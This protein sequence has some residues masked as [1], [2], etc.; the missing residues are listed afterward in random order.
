MKYWLNLLVSIDQF[1]NTLAGGNCDCT[2]S[3]HVGIMAESNQR[4]DNVKKMIDLTFE[5]IE[6]DHCIE[7]FLSDDDI[8]DTNNL[9]QTAIVAIIGCAVLYF[10]IRIIAYATR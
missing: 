9:I 1:F 7:S 2:I 6:E 3:G 5:P 10:P 8:D 4:W